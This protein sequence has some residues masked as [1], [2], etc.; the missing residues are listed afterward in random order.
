[1]R[2]LKKIPLSDSDK[3]RESYN[4]GE[5]RCNFCGK[6]LADGRIGSRT[7]IKIK[8]P[9]CKRIVTFEGL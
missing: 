5:L 7:E 9:R 6:R 2:K 1:M 4:K 3:V 8:C